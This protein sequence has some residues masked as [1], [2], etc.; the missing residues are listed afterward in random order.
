MLESVFLISLVSLSIITLLC[1]KNLYELWWRVFF[2]ITSGGLFGLVITPEGELKNEISFYFSF[3]FFSFIILHLFV[4][5]ALQNI[6]NKNSVKQ[7][8]SIFNKVDL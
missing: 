7:L 4:T 8:K 6:K 2:L 1:S 5:I 3:I